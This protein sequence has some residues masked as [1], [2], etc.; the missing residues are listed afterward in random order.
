VLA[1]AVAGDAVIGPPAACLVP[2]AGTLRP[3]SPAIALPT[4]PCFT[5]PTGTL[6]LDLGG[7]PVTLRDV[8]LSARFAGD[9]VDALADGLL[10]GFISETDANNTILPPT[11]PLI[12][13]QTLS[14]LL[15]GGS[16]SCATHSDKDVLDGVTGWW[17]YLNFPAS[18]VAVSGPPVA[19]FADG[20][21][22]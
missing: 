8:A 17:F 20:F 11:L 7:V 13:G 1:S 5:S 16:G 9:P 18:R 15:P 4:T 3:Y 10:R 6:T 2:E 12:G 22:P 14:S 19:V 21:E